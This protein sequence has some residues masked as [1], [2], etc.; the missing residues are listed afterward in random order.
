ME[1]LLNI[2]EAAAL[3]GVSRSLLYEMA[4]KKLPCIR[5]GRRILFQEDRLE[6]WITAHA[7]EPGVE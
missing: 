6:E 5:I 1:K 3:L 2:P 4:G 7:V